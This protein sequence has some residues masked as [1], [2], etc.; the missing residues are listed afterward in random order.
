MSIL[1]YL[2]LPSV[3]TELKSTIYS[4]NLFELLNHDSP[5]KYLRKLYSDDIQLFY[6]TRDEMILRGIN[7]AE[8]LE[9]NFFPQ[10]Q[11]VNSPTIYIEENHNKYKNINFN[12]MNLPNFTERF[13]VD[14]DLFFNNIPIQ[15]FT[16]LAKNTTI[17]FVSNIFQEAGFT[18]KNLHNLSEDKK[19]SEA[20]DLIHDIFPKP[21]FLSFHRYCFEKNYVYVSQLNKNIIKN[22]IHQPQVGEKKVLKVL[23]KYESYLEKTFPPSIENLINSSISF[24]ADNSL[25]TLFDSAEKDY[26]MFIEN[27]YSGNIFIDLTSQESQV[28]LNNF[29]ITISEI[30]NEKSRIAREDLLLAFKGKPYTSHLMNMVVS[31]LKQMLIKKRI[32]ANWPIPEKNILLEEIITEPQSTIIIKDLIDFQETIIPLKVQIESIKNELNERDLNCYTLRNDHSLTLQA[33]A[34]MIGI[35]R[36]RVRQIVKNVE[37]KIIKL[38]DQNNLEILLE[39]LPKEGLGISPDYLSNFYNIK[40]NTD[41]LILDSMIRKSGKYVFNDALKI[42][43]SKKI[44]THLIKKINEIEKLESILTIDEIT[45]HFSAVDIDF[46]EDRDLIEKIEEIMK[47]QG[48][49]NPGNLYYKKAISFKDKINYIF[50]HFITST[51][52][53]DDNG[54]EILSSLLQIH[55][56][57]D[58]PPNKKSVIGRIR[59]A[60]DVILVDSL[61]FS[62]FDPSTVNETF[63]SKLKQEIEEKLIIKEWINI[64]DVYIS[65]TELILQNNIQS[66]YHLYSLIQYFFDEDFDIGKGN[67]LNIYRS[68]VVKLNAVDSLEAF[69]IENDSSIS[70]EEIL[71]SFHWPPYRLDQLVSNSSKFISFDSKTVMLFSKLNMLKEERDIIIRLL[72]RSLE[73]G[74]AFCFEIFQEMQFDEKLS[75]LLNKYEINNHYSLLQL[76]KKISPEIKGH[77][78][79]MYYENC[80]WDSVEK[81][82]VKIFPAF[83]SR[84]DIYAHILNKGYSDQMAQSVV[85]ELMDK[86]HFLDYERN[87]VI[88]MKALSLDQDVL[89]GLK[90]Y[91]EELFKEKTYLSVTK[92]VGFKTNLSPLEIGGWTK[93]LIYHLGIEAGF[94][95]I[96]TANDYRFDK[97]LLVEPDSPFHTYEHLVKFILENEYSG[98]LHENN[99][100]KFLSET[101]LAHNDQKLSYE[102]KS[103]PLFNIDTLGWINL[104][105]ET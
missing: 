85:R 80:P 63:L 102:L 16:S 57:T 41:F 60:E 8:E 44:N 74:Y 30:L 53:M 73:S 3:S 49:I 18:I 91:L 66:R 40:S 31:D 13:N 2:T 52:K 39:F 45:A 72:K 89:D 36:E 6:A 95:A 10:T 104:K 15:G 51:I 24:F 65:N 42:Y 26:L 98:P 87:K 64:N 21:E 4:S 17:E 1:T 43:T 5:V 25:R 28:F 93:H 86:R 88:N 50:R 23:N 19:S 27:F 32:K 20:Q 12:L 92:L 71:E 68:N 61:T 94:R 46:I 37:K 83:T 56:G 101:G 76:I 70:K 79:Y 33:I 81:Y 75:L 35:T 67:T 14:S 7:L 77:S 48:Y 100:A 103:S 9:S 78:N 34:E 62:Y 105:E 96:K 38:T 47:L 84:K 54:F 29:E 69:L 22:F 59:D 11:Y 58:L 97:L 99:V 82:I 90:I 55:F